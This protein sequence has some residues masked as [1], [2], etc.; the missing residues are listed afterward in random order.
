MDQ[1]N[2]IMHAV[3]KMEKERL[4]NIIILGGLLLVSLF[5]IL[6]YCCFVFIQTIEEFGLGDLL[7]ILI[8]DPQEFLNIIAE[9]LSIFSEFLETEMIVA[10]VIS[11]IFIIIVLIK[12]DFPSLPKR[13]KETKKY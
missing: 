9:N 8:E 12:V 13:F 2:K 10:L 1:V 7:I 5:C 11:L 6:F 3:S 4:K